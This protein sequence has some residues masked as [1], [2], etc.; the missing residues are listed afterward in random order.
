[1]GVTLIVLKD[2][3]E[4]MHQSSLSTALKKSQDTKPASAHSRITDNQDSEEKLQ[5]NLAVVCQIPDWTLFLG[6]QRD[7]LI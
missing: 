5:L 1:M 3:Q 4:H 2:L 7:F 6:Y